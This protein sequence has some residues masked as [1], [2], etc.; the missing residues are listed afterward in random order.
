MI[1]RTDTE[2]AKAKSDDLIDA[3][4]T[5]LTDY[6]TQIL[7][8]GANDTQILC[9]TDYLPRYLN[10]A[11][12]F[13]SDDMGSDKAMI[14]MIDYIITAILA[15]VFAITTSSTITAEAGVIG[16]LRATG[17][18]K[19]EILTH[20]MILPVL[21]SLIAAVIGNILGY[22][23]GSRF[24][25]DVYYESYSLA[26]YKTLWN[27][28]ASWLTTI[29]PLVMMVLVNLFI[30]MRKLRLTPLQFLRR[31][32]TTHKKKKSFCLPTQ[33]PFFA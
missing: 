2:T 24:F 9:I 28:E 29:I 8:T 1:D 6:N 31:D 14:L 11:I 23:V 5:V 20:Y 30:L 7:T 26:A 3:I 4:E 16:T 27:A 22:T 15:F 21:I 33:I 19:R 13:T 12:N 17:Y 25:V 32:L 10:Q 18:T